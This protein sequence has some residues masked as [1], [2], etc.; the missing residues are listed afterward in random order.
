MRLLRLERQHIARRNEP[1]V[2]LIADV[3]EV[4]DVNRLSRARDI[5]HDVAQLFFGLKRAG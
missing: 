3:G 5:D 1:D 4:G 2:Q